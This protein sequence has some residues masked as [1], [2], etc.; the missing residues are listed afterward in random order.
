MRLLDF[1]TQVVLFPLGVQALSLSFL[2]A[3]LTTYDEGVDIASERRQF[4]QHCERLKYDALAYGYAQHSA[5]KH[6]RPDKALR[7]PTEPAAALVAPTP[8]TPG[9]KTTEQTQLPESKARLQKDLAQLEKE[10]PQF[11][12]RVKNIG[13]AATGLMAAENGDVLDQLEKV[14][15]VLTR[16]CK[17][18]SLSGLDPPDSLMD[19]VRIS[20]FIETCSFLAAAI[21]AAFLVSSTKRSLNTIYEN[22]IRH[23]SGSEL[24]PPEAGIDELATLDQSFRKMFE[25]VTTVL[26]AEKDLLHNTQDAMF[27]LDRTGSF[28]TANRSTEQLIGK[29]SGKSIADILAPSSKLDL[30]ALLTTSEQNCEDGAGDREGSSTKHLRNSA[31]QQRLLVLD[32]NGEMRPLEATIHWSMEDEAFYVTARDIS[33]EIETEQ[34]KTEFFRRVNEHLTKPILDLSQ[35]V[36]NL[37]KGVYGDL[38]DKG[39]SALSRA[40]SSLKRLLHMLTDLR[41]FSEAERAS[42]S[43]DLAP[44]NVSSLISNTIAEMTPFAAEKNIRM[45]FQDGAKDLEFPLDG[46]RMAQVLVNLL[47]NAVKFSEDHSAVTVKTLLLRDRQL[48]ISVIDQGRGISNDD[49]PKLFNRFQQ[50]RKT[51]SS[52]LGGSGLGLFICR[53]IV[54]KHGGQISVLSAPG[55]GAEFIITLTDEPFVRSS[56]AEGSSN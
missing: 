32:A 47:S 54:E 56:D 42:L 17:Q 51:D 23:S 38:A 13:Q 21:G 20:S 15:T 3:I 1:G 46:N 10:L 55:E 22:C 4:V 31:E 50:T 19:L 36:T 41:S 34:L 2:S 26:K 27:A 9:K 5:S 49:M 30:N 28:V 52:V 12:H 43:V 11:P 18:V 29:V 39:V 33:N 7:A 25:T 40:D 44:T 48:L 53:E 37:T 8:E 6:M 14:L 16:E 45:N 35:T 24:L